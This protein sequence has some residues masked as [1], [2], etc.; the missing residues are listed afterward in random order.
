MRPGSAGATVLAL[1]LVVGAA[2]CSGDPSPRE[3]A[4]SASSSGPSPTSTVASPTRTAAPS[5]MPLT[6]LPATSVLAGAAVAVKVDNVRPA[7]PQAGLEAADLVV[8]EPVEA[9]LTRLMAVYHSATPRRVGPVRSARVTDGSLTRAL[10]VRALVFSGASRAQLSAL[11]SEARARLVTQGRAPTWR[12][13]PSRPAPHNLYVDVAAVR[14]TLAPG[15]PRRQFAFDA[16]PPAGTRT[17]QATL[18]FGAATAGWTWHGQSRHWLRTQDG[19]TDVLEDRRRVRARNVVVL[20][21]AERTTSAF[22]DKGGNRTPLLTLEGSGR[23]WLLRDGVRVAAT[24]RRSATDAPFLLA[25]ARGRSVGLAPGT[26]WVEL[27]P[28]PRVPT[29]R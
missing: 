29:F 4:Q 26:T 21:V 16:Q 14:A 24:W 8:E 28:A 19:T 20:Q 15:A 3:P 13:D 1:A 6:G 5:T 2:A 22:R 11:R 23:A 9:G 18:R 10:D 17:G 25:D 12:R 27:L 7:R